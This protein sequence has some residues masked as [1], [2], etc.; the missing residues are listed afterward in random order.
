VYFAVAG[1]EVNPLVPPFVAFVVS[2]F[3]SMG[4]VSGAFLLLPFQMTFLGFT[5]PAVSATNQIYNI[6]AIPS[7]VWRYIR[8]GRMV[9]PLTWIV[10]AGTLPGVFIGAVIRVTFLPNPSDFRLFVGVVLFYIGARILRDLLVQLRDGDE[11]GS[12]EIRFQELARK[13]HLRVSDGE[14]LPHIEVAEFSL[15]RVVYSFYGQRFA[16]PVLPVLAISAVVGIVGGTYGIGGGAI[17]APLFVTYFGLPVYTVAGATLLGTLITSVA[18]VGFYEALAPLYPTTQVAP[19]WLLGLLFGVGGLAGMYCGARLQKF[20]PAR[21][22]KAIL[23]A[24]LFL[25]SGRYFFESLRR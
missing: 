23:A 7:G 13:Y 17:M 1:I 22:I 15:R 4:G 9:W 18:G 11:A 6:V 25:L 8:E 21:A 12:A 24:S 5:S 10:I 20:M 2:L 14:R 19:D 3:T 16:V